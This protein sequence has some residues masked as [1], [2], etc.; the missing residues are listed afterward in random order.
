MMGMKAKNVQKKVRYEQNRF[1]TGRKKVWNEQK[2]VW[3]E[4]KKV[5]NEQ[6]NKKVWNEQKNVQRLPH[7]HERRRWHDPPVG[8]RL[9]CVNNLSGASGKAGGHACIQQLAANGVRN[10][11]SVWCRRRSGRACTK[12]RAN[13]WRTF[14][15]RSTKRWQRCWAMSGGCGLSASG[16]AGCERRVCPVAVGV[17]AAEM[18]GDGRWVCLVGKRR[19]CVMSGGRALSAAEMIGDGRWACLVSSGDDW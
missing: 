11:E 7:A 13:C 5:W 10:A 2:K 6:K 19:C 15:R 14:M 1:G 16:D 18:I 12:R 3:N 17:S 8:R 4:Q 9:L